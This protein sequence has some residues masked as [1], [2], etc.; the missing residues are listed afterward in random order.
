[1][2]SGVVLDQKHLLPAVP[3]RQAVEK[4]GVASTFKDVALPVVELGPI[5]IDR[6]KDLLSVP[7]TRRRNQRLLSSTRPRL[8]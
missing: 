8:V 7:L 3:L 5:Q 2:V 6:S 1:M 4:G